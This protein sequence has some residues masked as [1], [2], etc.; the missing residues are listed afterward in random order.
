MSTAQASPLTEMRPPRARVKT[1]IHGLDEVLNGGFPSGHLYLIEGEPG[2]GKTTLALQFLLEGARQGE[3]GLYITLSETQQE[4]EAVARSHG[5]DLRPVTLFEMT[6]TAEEA[7]PEAQ[8]TVFHPS[9]IELAD[10][11]SSVLKR[12]EELNPKRVVFDSLSDLRMLARDPLRYR[13]QVLSLKRFFANRDCTVLLLD[14]RSTEDLDQLQSLTHGVIMMENLPREFGVKRR[15][16]E[17]RKLRGS[18]FR[19]GYHDFTIE[20]GGVQ[21]YPRLISA[22]HKAPLKRHTVASGI[23]ELDE[24]LGGGIHSGTST[25]L[26]GPAGGGKSTVAARYVV[27]AAER[28]DR[29][30]IFTFD[31]SKQTLLERAKGLGMDFEPHVKSGRI[32]VQQIDPAEIS[33]GE[34]VQRVRD[35]VRDGGVRIVVIDSLN[36]LIASMPGENYVAL[37]LHELLSFCAQLGVVTLITMAQHGFIGNSMTVPTDISYLADTVIVFR[38]FE[39]Q[40]QMKQAISVLKKRSGRHE[41]AIRELIFADGSL[42][43][44]HPLTEFEGVLTGNPRYIGNGHAIRH[45]AARRKR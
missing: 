30:A 41:R 14:D 26:M 8:Y 4:L 39:T 19:E 34:F 5:W 32:E 24:L 43:V 18:R 33:P 3:G 40:G 27:S 44:G 22:E 16:L 20:T 36:G 7:A 29:C 1:G 31:E 37:Q 6:P 21:L 23:R 42:T 38:F 17:V 35:R 45:R 10:I 28:G 11:T 9:E 12:I 25:L 15:R 2:S 13:R